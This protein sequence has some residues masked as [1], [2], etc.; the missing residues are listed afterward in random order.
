MPRIDPYSIKARETTELTNDGEVK[1]ITFNTF[2]IST[3]TQDA[4]LEYLDDEFQS[5]QLVILNQRLTK[6]LADKDNL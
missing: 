4:L 2:Y 5:Q 6:L 3:L 1:N